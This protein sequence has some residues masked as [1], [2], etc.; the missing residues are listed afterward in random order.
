MP[1]PA[2]PPKPEPRSSSTSLDGMM[3]KG[4]EMQMQYLASLQSIF[5]NADKTGGDKS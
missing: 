4:R 5:T 1:P 2:E 3:E